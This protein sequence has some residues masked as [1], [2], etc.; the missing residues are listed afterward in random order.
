MLVSSS[1]GSLSCPT[2]IL[3]LDTASVYSQCDWKQTKVKIRAS[4]RYQG[5]EG[6]GLVCD[7][8]APSRTMS[9]L[10]VK[11]TTVT[12]NCLS[13]SVC[14]ITPPNKNTDHLG[15]CSLQVPQVILGSDPRC[16]P[17]NNFRRTGFVVFIATLVLFHLIRS[18]TQPSFRSCLLF[19]A[20]FLLLLS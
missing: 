12:G 13:S 14:D 17:G 10:R 19:V 20:A 11:Q 1:R 7:A 3:I 5:L 4:R 2:P 18:V 9:H 15:N 16:S 8:M 6:E